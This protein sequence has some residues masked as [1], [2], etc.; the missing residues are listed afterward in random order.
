[1]AYVG[2]G[3]NM[4]GLT[5]TVSGNVEQTG[6]IV[7]RHWGPTGTTDLTDANVTNTTQLSVQALFITD[8]V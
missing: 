2:Y 4:S 6:A 8:E 1:M 3:A 7:L 5:G